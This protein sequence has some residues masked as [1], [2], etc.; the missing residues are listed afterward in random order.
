MFIVSF[1]D[2]NYLKYIFKIIV[3]QYEKKSVFNFISTKLRLM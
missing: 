2:I 3:L 1:F